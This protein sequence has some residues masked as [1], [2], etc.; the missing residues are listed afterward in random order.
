MKSPYEIIKRPI[1]TERS[2]EG[3]ADGRYTFEVAKKLTQ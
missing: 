1:I 2:A 3:M